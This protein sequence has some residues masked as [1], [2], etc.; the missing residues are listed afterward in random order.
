M[1]RYGACIVGIVI[2]HY[3]SRFISADPYDPFANSADVPLYPINAVNNPGILFPFGGDIPTPRVHQTITATSDYVIV[4]GGYSTDGS[5]LGDINLFYITSQ[6]WSGP[7]T[8]Q[9]CCN[10]EGEVIETIGLDQRNG[11]EPI[12]YFNIRPGFEGDFPYPRAEHGAC[13]VSDEMYVFGGF[14]TEQSFGY[15]HD[16]YK[17]SP[18]QMQWTIIELFSTIEFPLR[19]AGHS[20]VCDDATSRIFVFGGRTKVGNQNPQRS[21]S[22]SSTYNN[23]GLSDV[24]QY[25]VLRRSWR[26]LSIS[27]T[28]N[29]PSP[30]QHASMT[31]INGHLYLFGGIDPSSGRTYNDMWVFYVGSTTWKV[32]YSTA[33]AENYAFAPP[34]LYNAHLL[35]VPASLDPHTGVNTTSTEFVRKSSRLI[36]NR[37]LLVYGGIG[38]GGV[39]GNTLQC[40]ALETVLGQVYR[41]DL[42]ENSWVVPQSVTGDLMS[43]D[44]KFVSPSTWLY[45]RISGLSVHGDASG[46]IW[47]DRGK[48]IKSFALEEVVFIPSRNIMYEFGGMMTVA[49]QLTEAAQNST[50]STEDILAAT[51]MNPITVVTNTIEQANSAPPPPS[52]LSLSVNQPIFLSAASGSLQTSHWDR[53]TGEQLRERVDVPTN[54]AW[55]YSQAFS[56]EL[57]YSG[58]GKPIL[59]LHAFR[60]YTISPSDIV[61]VK[62]DVSTPL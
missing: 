10:V 35:P 3:I 28:S 43:A 62:E 59:F 30:R 14:S 16:L 24:W 48:L 4:Y 27:G 25:D 5:V 45:A 36:E 41:F 58:A 42:S 18:M 57:P 46:D 53:Q 49:K 51:P 11:S 12:Q 9:Q 50:I 37:G 60:T 56:Q 32:L 47:N 54:Y 34:P 20:M 1:R 19:R 31:L 33:A 15:M 22:D 29:G 21:P 17:F 7:I 23:V 44:A 61:L 13:V 40:G 6:Q 26:V 55:D 38:G 52:T 2:S 39:C 8:R